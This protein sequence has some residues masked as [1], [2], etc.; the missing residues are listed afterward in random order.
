M[1]YAWA[2][3]KVAVS[4]DGAWCGRSFA[5]A[6]EVNA[7]LLPVKKLRQGRSNV[8]RG[9]MATQRGLLVQLQ[10]ETSGVLEPDMVLRA[11]R[12][13]I[14]TNSAQPKPGGIPTHR[15][16]RI[17]NHTPTHNTCWAGKAIHPGKLTII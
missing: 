8:L 5:G 3:A 10:E 12:A 7:P 6:Q 9:L 1:P 4:R 14:S 17:G 13:F 16:A 11:G 2:L 15:K